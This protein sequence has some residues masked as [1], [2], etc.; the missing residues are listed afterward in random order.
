M[1]KKQ[2]LLLKEL[3]EMD[4][5]NAGETVVLSSKKKES[6]SKKKEVNEVKGKE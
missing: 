1:K 6:V 3:E 4:R 5:V 2:A